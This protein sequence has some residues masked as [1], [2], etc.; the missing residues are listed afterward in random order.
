MKKSSGLFIIDSNNKLLVCHP[1]NH[2][3]DFWTIPKGIDEPG[4]TSLD[5]A[6]RETLE[7]TAFDAKKHHNNGYF[8]MYYNLGE[9]VYKTNQKLVHLH[10]L[11]SDRPL[12]EEFTNLKCLT[13]FTHNK[14]GESLKENDIVKWADFESIIPYLHEAQQRN[15]DKIKRMLNILNKNGE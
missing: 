4:E 7:E 3:P 2:A 10:L 11:V 9:T 8:S 13:Y 5:A 14:T 15:I 1:T 6:F 12:S